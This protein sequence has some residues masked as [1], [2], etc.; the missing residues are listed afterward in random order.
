MRFEDYPTHR[1]ALMDGIMTRYLDTGGSGVPVVLIHGLAAS[2]EAWR[3]VVPELAARRRVLALDLPGFGYADKPLGGDYTALGFFLPALHAFLDAAGVERAHLVGSSM[4]ASL[5]IRYAARHPGRVA[6]VTAANPGG[7]DRYIHP[8]LRVPT[9]PGVGQV[10]SRPMRATNAFA[11]GLTMARKARRT[12]ALLDEIDMF[13]KLPGAH[14]DFVKTL[15]GL[16][17]P[18]GLKDLEEF[19]HDAR[20]V[21]APTLI[22]WGREDRIFPMAQLETAEA[23]MPAAEVLVM[24]GVGHFPQIDAPAAFAARVVSFLD[25]LEREAAPG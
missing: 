17:T 22:V 5:A 2:I 6:S 14:N 1:I 24:D 19:A 20:A 4:G 3:D 11:M 25:G 18:L 9:V 7:F 8:F 15:R 23:M 13:S 21:A 16:A 12:Q 10:V